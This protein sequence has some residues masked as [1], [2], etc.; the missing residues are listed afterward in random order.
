MGFVE[1]FLKLSGFDWV[2]PDYSTVCRRQK[3]LPVTISARPN[4]AG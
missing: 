4:T 2:V 3:V 1:S